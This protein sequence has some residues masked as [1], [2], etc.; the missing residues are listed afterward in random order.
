MF[1]DIIAS[2]VGFYTNEELAIAKAW[3]G[4]L[5]LCDQYV[6]DI[7]EHV[8]KPWL[9]DKLSEAMKYKLFIKHYA[10]YKICKQGIAD[11]VKAEVFASCNPTEIP[12]YDKKIVSKY[13]WQIRPML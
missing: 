6:E 4:K 2:M 12:N 7:Y 5:K 11:R 10:N 3:K 1:I 9:N 8:E 13:V